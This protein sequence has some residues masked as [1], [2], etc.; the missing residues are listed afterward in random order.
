MPTTIS[1]AHNSA[2]LPNVKLDA[3]AF[4]LPFLVSARA[5]AV[6]LSLNMLNVPPH[7]IYLL[8]PTVRLAP[9]VTLS[10]C[11]APAYACPLIV[12][13]PELRDIPLLPISE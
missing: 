5:T 2:P 11:P 4:M 6:V 13:L 8:E 9:L 1:F 10:P 3:P 12:A 7:I